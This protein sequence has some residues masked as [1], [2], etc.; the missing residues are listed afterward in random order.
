MRLVFHPLVQ[1]DLREALGFYERTGSTQ[2]ADRFWSDVLSQIR[3]L[4]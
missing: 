1:R 2:L 3:I 4:E